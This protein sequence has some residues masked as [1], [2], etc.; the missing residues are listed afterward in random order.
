MLKECLGFPSVRRSLKHASAN[1]AGKWQP[2]IPKDPG[3]VESPLPIFT[4]KCWLLTNMEDKSSN[5]APIWFSLFPH[6]QMF[7]AFMCIHI[8]AS[9][10][11]RDM[12]TLAP[13]NT[14]KIHWNMMNSWQLERSTTSTVGQSLSAAALFQRAMCPSV[15]TSFT[16]SMHKLCFGQQVQV[17]LDG[18][19]SY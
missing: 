14:G 13:S 19:C 11:F 3:R 4:F 17:W 1:S 2:D 5:S 6:L 18:S 12:H 8:P 15:R 9:A 10:F 16:S 7:A